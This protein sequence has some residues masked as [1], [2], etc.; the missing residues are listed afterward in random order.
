MENYS[1]TFERSPPPYLRGGA[2]ELEWMNL[3]NATYDATALGWN[4][5]LIERPANPRKKLTRRGDGFPMWDR[6]QPAGERQV[7][8]R[9]VRFAVD[10]KVVYY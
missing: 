3:Q 6:R 5:A 8:H 1:N 2:E 7:V 10:K 4:D 9:C